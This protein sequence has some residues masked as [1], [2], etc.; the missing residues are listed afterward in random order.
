MRRLSPDD[1]WKE[2]VA[3]MWLSIA[4]FVLRVKSPD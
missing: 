3:L 4:R 2:I 1:R